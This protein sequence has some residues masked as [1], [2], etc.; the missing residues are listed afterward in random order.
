MTKNVD[1][2]VT[3]Q[4]FILTA[5][6]KYYNFQV[7]DTSNTA[8]P[9]WATSH[10]DTWSVYLAAGLLHYSTSYASHSA[11]DGNRASL[12]HQQQHRLMSLNRLCAVLISYAI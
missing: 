2:S 11:F 7:A 4:N 8:Q 3:T 9:H 12:Q 6:Y 5:L 1:T 10:F